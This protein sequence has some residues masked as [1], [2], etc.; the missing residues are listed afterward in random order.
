MFDFL[1]YIIFY[2]STITSAE[3]FVAKLFKSLVYWL[4]V[5]QAYAGSDARLQL[6]DSE[7]SRHVAHPNLERA[8]R[9]IEVS[10]AR[11]RPFC[12][13][14]TGIIISYANGYHF[15]MVLL[16]RA[17]L[18]F[19][20]EAACVLS[21]FILV[22]IDAGCMR[23]CVA[24]NISNCVRWDDSREF[25]KSD[26][27]KNDYRYITYLKW[28]IIDVVLQLYSKQVFF[29]D[30]DVALFRN[31]FMY[32]YDDFDFEFQR[33]NSKRDSAVN[34]G[35]LFFSN[36]DRSR[37]MVRSMVA[38]GR[39]IVAAGAPL[40][41]DF[42]HDALTESG[43]SWHSLDSHRFLGHCWAKEYIS[44]DTLIKDIVTY[45]AHCASNLHDKMRVLRRVYDAV[46][47]FIYNIDL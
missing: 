30:T 13:A 35:Q 40:D 33:E 32:A 38:R 12:S 9:E 11:E 19:F 22:C 8:I 18:K 44:N 47:K 20:G 16:Q 21:R 25:K 26:F 43:S 7:Q 27:L 29:F 17:S 45:H 31:P 28:L 24:H 14:R 34:G 36:T 15:D 23:K 42:V 1:C 4:A 5:H 2:A 6:I 41:Q 10:H 37:S 39:Y 3:M 46:E